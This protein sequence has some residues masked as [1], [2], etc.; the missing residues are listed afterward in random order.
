MLEVGD[1]VEDNERL[2]LPKRVMDDFEKY[3]KERGITG[4]KKEKL[5]EMLRRKFVEKYAYEP[6]EAIGIVAAQ[7]ISEPATQMSLDYNEK[8]IVKINGKIRI[9]KIGEFIDF[10]MENFGY[11][12]LNRSEV[13]ALP[14]YIKILVPSITKDERIEWKRV[15]EVSR[16]RVRER[17][18]KI[19]TASGRSIIATP[20]HSFVT[21]K[22]NE[23][24]VVSGNELKIGNRI[25]VIRYLKE[26]CVAGLK[27][28]EII[29]KERID[30]Y[31]KPIEKINLDFDFGWFIG[32][33]LA[34]GNVTKYF[35][36]ISN[37]NEN[38]LNRLR[39]FAKKYNLNFNEY[40]NYRGF[41]KSHD[42]HI[43]SKL[44]VDILRKTCYNEKGEKIVPQ[45]AYSAKEQFVAGLLRGYFDGD[46]NISVSKHVI[47]VSSTSK[48]LIDGISL[49][50]TRFGIFATK[51]R[52]KKESTLHIYY[53]YA[54]TFLEK[55]GSDVKEKLQALKRLA[56]LYESAKRKQDFI[57]MIPEVGDS[58]YNA[59]KRVKYP[60]RY[61]NNFTKRQRIGRETLKRYI[62]LFKKRAKE[63]NIELKE[64]E[65][66]EK[67]ANSHVIWDKIVKI[68]KVNSSSKYV[69]DFSVEGTETFATFD[70]I[71]THN[72]MRSYTLASL[73]GSLTKVVQGLPRMIEIFDLRQSYDKSM[74]IYLK[75]E[76]NDREK[77]LRFASEIK[78]TRISD[79]I[80]S[81]SIDLLNMQ[82]E[83]EFSRKD[84]CMLAYEKIKKM[85]KVTRREKKLVVKPEE[86]D[87]K[88]LRKLKQRVLSTKIRGVDGIKNVIVVKE[89]NNWVIQ[90]T[91]SN[92]KAILADPRVDVRRT[93][94]DDI[95][96]IYETL[97]IEAARNAILR[98]AKSTLDEQGL[99]VDIRHLMLVADIMCVDGIPKP[100]GRYG[101]AGE[102]P[103]VLARANFEETKKHLRNAAI[104]GRVDALR[105]VF[106]N[107]MLNRVVPVGTGMTEIKLDMEKLKQLR[108]KK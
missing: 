93:T 92:L 90:T 82:L 60:V 34:E 57:D 17:L 38:Y 19:T 21:R 3:C 28:N 91:G 33:F 49:L 45:F 100:I 81:S 23:I 29:E 6:G 78:E 61:V 52:N 88:T 63:L 43:Y 56:S 74:R 5:L 53:K 37:T 48:E 24:K 30:A 9:V 104:R 25:P 11:E 71:I 58:L 75:P 40:D 14:G 80:V 62:K 98:E 16:H 10:L 2:A 8:V 79:V 67:A 106:E 46:G 55:I 39:N 50:L 32:A 99:D 31:K 89:G 101:V 35:V 77:A 72:T 94:T 54:R 15:T 83:F 69:Y 51:S 12:N 26:N 68:E 64:L 70:G 108:K 73:V 84:E 65:I 18:L 13:C 102:K 95:Y 47:R 76:Y 20:Y 59:A 85:G 22:N 96:Q 86:A 97:G 7:S 4:E 66:L 107:V 103:S 41:A 87:I 105:G 27:V 36:S 44:L 1:V 42:V